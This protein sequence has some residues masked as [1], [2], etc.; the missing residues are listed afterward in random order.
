[1]IER[2]VTYSRRD[3]NGD[4]LALGNASEYWSPRLKAAAIKDIEEQIFSYFILDSE[5]NRTYIHVEQGPSGK[6]LRIDPNG[7]GKVNLDNLP[8]G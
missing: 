3:K 1:M 7:S 8:S 5:G 4:I 6:Y 2:R